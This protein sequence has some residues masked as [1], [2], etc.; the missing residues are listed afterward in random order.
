MVLA[1]KFSAKLAF[2]CA[3]LLP[4]SAMADI[5]VIQDIR[6]EGL[7]RISAGT[8]FNY[9]PVTVGQEIEEAQT[10]EV[11][12]ALYKTGF[13]KDVRLERDGD[14]LVIFVSERPA[15]ASIDFSGNEALETEKLIE[16]LK[17][18]GLAEG[19]VFNRSVLD[20]IEQELRRQYFS[21]G[22]YGVKLTSTVTPLERNRVG[23]AIDISEGKAATIK[24]INI[25][26]NAAFEDD[27]LL[28]VFNLS[29]GGWLS[30]YTKN[31]QY[32]RQQLSGD[33]EVLRSFYLDRGY[34]NF[35]I[36]STQVS[37]TPDKKDIYITINVSEGDVYTI[38]DI[39]LAG[40]LV[41]PK[42]EMFGLIHLTRGHVFSR[43]MV[44]GSSERINALLGDHGYAFANVN[45][46]PEMDDEKHQ[47]SITYFV[48]PGKRVYV[49]RINLRGNTR[50]R[51]R[52]LRREMRQMESAW[53]SA[54]NVS[55]SRDRLE[56]LSFF[57]NVT[58]ETP[59]VPG[60]TD[61][62]DVN[63]TVKEKPAGNLMAGI[64]FSQSQG[65]T[66]NTSVA[67]ANFLGTGKN[68]T[69]AFNTSSSNTL[70]QL[71]Y[72]N[73]YYTIDG[74]SRGFNLKYRQT[75][76]DELDT[77][78][79][80]TDVM[81]AGVNFGIPIGEFDRVF[82]TFDIENTDFQAASD[83]SNEI[84]EFEAEHGS[85]LLD[86]KAGVSWV[87]DSRNSIMFPTRGG[88]Q[89]AHAE[90][91]FPGSDLE[92]Y[93]VS[94]KRQ[95]YFPLSKIFTLGM[96]GHIGYGDGYAGTERLPFYENFFAGGFR[97]VRG[98]A[99]NTLGRRDSK[100]EALGANLALTG[101]AEIY[102]KAP[103]TLAEKSLR[104]SVFTDAGNV[105]NMDDGAE[106]FEADEIRYS[107]GMS[108]VWVSPMGLL[109]FS[110]AQPLN[111]SSKDETESFQFNFGS[112]F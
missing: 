39:K 30:F 18:I 54:G 34:I 17:D 111:T 100:D 85:N 105:F 70:Y 108:A 86:Y 44:V 4:F 53:F 32:S 23:I 27:D 6:V 28:D 46:I 19:R 61:Q 109:T 58:V 99:T 66:F 3:L 65:I 62:V 29:T 40:E 8:V 21:Q 36:E 73:P 57:E 64:G 87:Y 81:I 13:F 95:Q 68:V 52:V 43:K 10:A 112:S 9:M 37:I 103:F 69:L 14:V 60:S 12:R 72:T 56:R 15:V 2:F 90:V 78:D 41:V 97:S 22:K 67:Q 79:Y 31:D 42:E 63:V 89:R 98:Y 107:A 88:T 96:K 101:G 45:S 94:Y 82:F 1:P 47:V 55:L 35:K 106:G 84:A 48:D 50:T 74:I 5:F 20:K 33:L 38:S 11:I 71:A 7:Q 92:Y 51:D 49:R 59:P 80:S 110:L 75:E 24:N 91:T 102:F 76:F 93:K 83:A 26:G 25:V 104:L 77:A 16:A